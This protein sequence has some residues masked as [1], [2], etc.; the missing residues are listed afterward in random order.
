MPFDFGMHGIS[1]VYHSYAYR[2]IGYPHP[3][4]DYMPTANFQEDPGRTRSSEVRHT[5][6]IC[7]LD[8]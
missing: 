5:L 1:L 6:L 2:L 8:I 3:D 4:G 7:M